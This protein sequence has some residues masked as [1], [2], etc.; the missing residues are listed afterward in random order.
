MAREN[1]KQATQIQ[2]KRHGLGP[3]ETIMFI[4]AAVMIIAGLAGY[5]PQV[6]YEYKT[7]R[8]APAPASIE[9]LREYLEK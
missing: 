5:G 6:R 4:V 9:T 3:M 1:R 7:Y 8:P 2:R